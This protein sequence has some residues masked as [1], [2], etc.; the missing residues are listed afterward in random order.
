MLSTSSHERRG[1]TALAAA[2]LYG[3]VSRFTDAGPTVPRITL[4][5]QGGRYSQEQLASI[6]ECP[7]PGWSR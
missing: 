3:R 5:P 4:A 2:L 6:T 1:A 7:T